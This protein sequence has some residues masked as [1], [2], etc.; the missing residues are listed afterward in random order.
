[1][2]F[3]SLRTSLDQKACLRTGEEV[4]PRKRPETASTV[5]VEGKGLCCPLKPHVK[6]SCFGSQMKPPRSYFNPRPATTTYLSIT[7]YAKKTMS[8]ISL[9]KRRLRITFS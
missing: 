5:F 2:A 6:S 8:S 7:D 3:L 4:R 1:M 9:G